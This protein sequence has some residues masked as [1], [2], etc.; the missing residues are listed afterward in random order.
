[1]WMKAI[2]LTHL[3]KKKRIKISKK[4]KKKKKKT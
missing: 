2:D 4:K 1:L 3:L